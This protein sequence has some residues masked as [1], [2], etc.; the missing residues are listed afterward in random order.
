MVLCQPVEV[1]HT[2]IGDQVRTQSSDRIP[3]VGIANFILEEFN[4]VEHLFWFQT[5]VHQG[6][7]MYNV[8]YVAC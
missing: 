3:P 7:E 5:I 2:R 8:P 1:D 6:Q 4:F